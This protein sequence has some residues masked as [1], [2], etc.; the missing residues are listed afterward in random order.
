MSTSFQQFVSSSNYHPAAPGLDLRQHLRTLRLSVT[1]LCNF[2]CRYCMPLSGVSKR[3]C[4]DVLPLERLT[5]LVEW[6]ITHTGIDSIRLTGGEPLVRSGLEHLI[7]QVASLPKVREVSLTTNGSLLRH[8]AWSLKAAGLTRVNI[9]LDSTDTNRF[10]EV[11]RGGDLRHVLAGI[12]AAKEAGLVPIKLNSV[13]RRSTWQHDVPLLLD[14]VVGTGL[15]I[16]FI[17]LMRTGTERQWCESEF[18]SAE[19]V[20]R[21]LRLDMT[22]VDTT[23]GEGPAR[24]TLV[25]WK[26]AVLPVGWITPRSRPFCSNCGRLRMDSLGRIRRCLMDP[27]TLDLATL[28]RMNEETAIDLFNTYIADKMPPTTMENSSA[29]NE[30]GG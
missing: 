10:A 1:D 15:E 11:T 14:Y 18:I 26:G 23:K 13:L 12:R 5:D 25:N 8:R 19:N 24:R 7:A 27:V 2:R 20:C 9:S 30:I 17:E 3:E 21:G 16:R 6:L 29:M 4:Q 28:L 22:W